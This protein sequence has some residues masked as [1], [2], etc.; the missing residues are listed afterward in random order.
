LLL[1]VEVVA[2]KVVAVA[3][4]VVYLQDMRESRLALLIL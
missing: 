4:L 2:L 3:V 1:V